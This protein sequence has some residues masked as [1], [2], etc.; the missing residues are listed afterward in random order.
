[1]RTFVT[2]NGIQKDQILLAKVGWTKYVIEID[3]NKFAENFVNTV[4]FFLICVFHQKVIKCNNKPVKWF[5]ES[6]INMRN[7][8]LAIKQ[9]SDIMHKSLGRKEL[10]MMLLQVLKMPSHVCVTN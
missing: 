9:I 10:T 7:K 2:Q 3:H 1:M 4:T 5:N 8:L 6:L